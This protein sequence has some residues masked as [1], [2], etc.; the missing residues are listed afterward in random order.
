MLFRS[1][2]VRRLL[3][4]AGLALG[5]TAGLGAGVGGYTFFYARGASY[6]TDAPE[7]CA[8]CHVMRDHFE[9]WRKS[10]H[11]AVAVCNDCHTPE[12]LVPKYIT[13]GLNGWHHSVAFTTGRFHEPIQIT[14]RNVAVAESACRRCHSEITQ[15]IDPG[16]AAGQ[17]LSCI[18]CH[19]SV[20]HLE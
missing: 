18:Q 1:R 8:N 12:G 6:M 2:N 13:K 5:L 4:S 14:P 19:Q 9:A 17:P 15:A 11:H 16:H 3:W 20:G 10:S 7:A